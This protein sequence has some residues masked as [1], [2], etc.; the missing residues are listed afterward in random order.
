MERTYSASPAERFFTGGGTHVFRNF[1]N[2]YDGSAPPV[3][4][5]FRNSVNLVFVRMMRDIERFHRARLPAVASGLLDDPESPERRRYLERFADREGTQFISRFWAKYANRGREDMV[6]T[7]LA[8]RRQ[9]PRRLAWTI[10]SILPEIDQAEFERIL[11]ERSPD[12]EFSPRAVTDLY[13]MADPSS[14]GLADRAYLAGVHPLELWVVA[15]RIE[16]PEATLNRALEASVDVRQEVYGWL[17]SSRRRQ[18]QERS[19]SIMLEIES[20][21]EIQRA[22]QRL[23]YPFENLVPSY[24]SAIGSSGDRPDALAELIGIILNDGIRLPTVRIRGLV[25]GVGTPYET[26]W[27]ARPAVGEAVMSNDVAAVVRGALGEVVADGTARSV[28]DGVRD[29]SGTPVTVGGKTG[30]GN[31]QMK[32]FGSGGGLVRTRTINRTATFAFYLG[33]RH[34]GVVTAHVNGEE[35]VGYTFT[36]A[37]PLAVLRL[38]AP[39][40]AHLFGSAANE[41][42]AAGG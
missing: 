37:L 13:R 36:S 29:A 16:D 3:R 27:S 35:A 19:I 26:H 31:N 17:F 9:T 22:W 11:R 25:F 20:F 34:F 2:T 15:F 28:R 38:A 4:A 33:D 6:P 5:G 40:L 32:V 23:G 14:F 30:T 21:L 41:Q 42:T 12:S 7:L 18:A 39:G 8:G 10:R 24:G 1:D